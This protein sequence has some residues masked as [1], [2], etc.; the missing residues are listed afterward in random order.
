MK[1]LVSSLIVV[2]AL[3]VSAFSTKAQEQFMDAEA[4]A[5]ATLLHDT[6]RYA[7]ELSGIDENGIRFNCFAILDSELMVTN[8]TINNKSIPLP[9][10]LGGIPL[11]TNGLWNAYA[12]VRALDKYGDVGSQGQSNFDYLSKGD[13]ISVMMTPQFP[14][15][16]V[17]IGTD[18]DPRDLNVEINS[19]GGWGSSYD[20]RTGIIL[21]EVFNPT[22]T[23]LWY[24]ITGYNGVLLAQDWLPLLQPQGG[25]N[26][27]SNSALSLSNAGGVI[28]VTFTQKRQYGQLR[29]VAFDSA[30]RREGQI[31][32]AKVITVS[33]LRDAMLY[34]SIYTRGG[35][36]GKIE[37]QKWAP[38]GPMRFVPIRKIVDEWGNITVA[39]EERLEKAVVTV[40]PSSEVE[41]TNFEMFLSPTVWFPGGMG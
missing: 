15:T 2:L 19:S 17:Y 37:V 24:R 12:Y 18:L 41:D 26:A 32:K 31:V 35:G 11:P 6:E 20:P 10:P 13:R 5:Q 25:N 1:K 4:L 27:S 16:G 34:F 22:T 36:V 21:L 38:S 33:G 7:L 23:D 40:Y 8:L 9:K 39:T 3:F 14:P 28:N 29:K 30:V